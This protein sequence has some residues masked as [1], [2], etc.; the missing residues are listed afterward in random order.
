MNWLSIV[1]LII[2]IL[3]LIFFILV[4]IVLN[5]VRKDK[6]QN[7]N[8]VTISSGSLTGLYIGAIIFAVISGFQVL[9]SIAALFRPDWFGESKCKKATNHY[10]PV[11][12]QYTTTN[13]PASNKVAQPVISASGT[14]VNY[15]Q[16]PV[17]VTN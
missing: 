5:Q 4:A 17:M 13:R 12:Q 9:G 8:V 16:P 3:V 2:G 6:E 1:S 14:T 15:D 7:P 11:N 10:M